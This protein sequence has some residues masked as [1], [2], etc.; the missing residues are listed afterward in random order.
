[1]YIVLTCANIALFGLWLFALRYFNVPWRKVL[2]MLPTPM[3]GFASSY[4]VYAFNERLTPAWVAIV[5]AAAFETTYVGIAALNE[6]S[7]SQVGRGDKIARDAA[8]ISY[9]QNAIA[10]IFYVQPSLLAYNTGMGAWALVVNLPLALLHA[11]QVWIAYRAANFTLHGSSTAE[12][13]LDEKTP[14]TVNVD[15]NWAIKVVNVDEKTPP[16]SLPEVD[17][18]TLYDQKKR[19]YP[20]TTIDARAAT[21]LAQW[22]LGGQ[23]GNLTQIEIAAANDVSKQYVSDVIKAYRQSIKEV[24]ND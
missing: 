22:K 11:S 10:A 21:W 20:P 5:M 4:G 23:G 18:D 8:I 1:M 9:A 16:L 3:L 19:D 15:Q 14:Q 13:Q 24:T 17:E 6:L 7:T 2:A 12:H